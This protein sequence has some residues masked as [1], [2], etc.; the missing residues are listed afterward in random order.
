MSQ[1]GLWSPWGSSQRSSDCD[2]A[3]PR[4]RPL[5]G[6]HRGGK[7]LSG[8]EGGVPTSVTAAGNGLCLVKVMTSLSLTLAELS[9]RPHLAWPGCA[10]DDH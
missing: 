4:L 3:V 5:G 2:P 10:L 1:E 8:W 7:E 9:R 6:S